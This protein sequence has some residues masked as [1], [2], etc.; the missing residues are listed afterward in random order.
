MIAVGSVLVVVFVSLL[1]TRVATVALMSTGL[2]KDIAR[3][4]ARSALTGVG[5]TTTEAERI[6]NHPVRRRVVMFLMLVG[7][8]GLVTVV[9]G[10]IFSF[11]GG[12]GAGQKL[13]R[14]GII[15]GGLV[16][17]F[18]LSKSERVD[19]WMT[20]VIARGLSRYTDLE[21]RD[22]V[23]L[24]QLKGGYGVTEVRVQPGDWMEGRTLAELELDREGILVLGIYRGDGTYRGAPQGDT[25]MLAGDEV[26]VY[27]RA[28]LLADLHERRK[29]YRGDRA[30]REAVAEQRKIVEEEAQEDPAAGGRNGPTPEH[31]EPSHKKD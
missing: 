17:L 1:I 13:I 14:L 15:L 18:F 21:I 19:R 3:F 28:Q 2:S 25:E 4:Q 5:Y 9:A 27:G 23:R 29:G 12:A 31:P 11:A 26:V 10:V 24:L 7:N 22:Y 6:V 30:H 20:R 8:A 16:A